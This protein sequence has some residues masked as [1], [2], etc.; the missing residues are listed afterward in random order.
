M[1][2]TTEAAREEETQMAQSAASKKDL[3]LDASS[4]TDDPPLEPDPES[5]TNSGEP[6]RNRVALVTKV[7]GN[8]SSSTSHCEENFV[9]EISVEQCD[10]GSTRPEEAREGFALATTRPRPTLRRSNSSAVFMTSMVSVCASLAEEDRAIMEIPTDVYEDGPSKGFRSER[11]KKSCAEAGGRL[12]QM[13]STADWW[14]LWIGLI[15]FVLAIILIFTVQYDHGSYRVKYV[16][17]QPMRWETNPFDA[18]DAYGFL[19]TILLLVFL[20]S[21]YLLALKCCGKLEASSA[22][23]HAKGFAEMGA[24]ATLAFWLGRNKWCYLNGLGYAVFSIILGMIIA[25]SPLASKDRLSS[26]KLASKEGEFFIKCSLALLAVE[27]SVLGRVGL[28]A[29]VV[30]WVGS[31]LALLL[32]YFLAVR[33]FKMDTSL[34]LLI[35]V[36]ATWCGASAISAVGS[37]IGS[38]SADISLCISVVAFFT[39]IFTFIQP[40]IAIGVGMDEHVAGAW[41]GGSVDQ[42]GNVIA[43]AAIIS[44]EATEVAAIVKIVLNSGLGILATAIAFWW[45]TKQGAQD[46]DNQSGKKSLSWLFIWD[47]FPKFVLGYFLCSG[48][49]SIVLPIIQG[50]AEADAMQRAIISMNKWWFAIGFVGIGMGTKIKDLWN[51]AKKS[52]VVQAYLIGNILDIGIALGLSYAMF[53]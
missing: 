8:S 50:T 2:S 52:G 31:P 19:G 20:C 27:F 16:I 53:K 3:L 10:D 17:P 21:L 51:G 26:L 36:G 5:Q 46:S 13:H 45:Q 33:L 25:N 23:K 4:A 34:A 12:E 43:S 14:S 22:T 24:I 39:V 41:I 1:T 28:S 35:A 37:V 38:S 18:W 15:S 11:K 40:Y 9:D 47:K 7:E 44:E 30:A 6:L 42:T 32:G 29:I 49:L 48:V